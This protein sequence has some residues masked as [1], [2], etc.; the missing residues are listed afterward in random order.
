[1]NILYIGEE[2]R[3][4]VIMLVNELS[5]LGHTITAI[6]K[7]YDEY[8]DSNK[9][10]PLENVTVIEVEDGV[11]FS[12]SL[13][14]SMFGDKTLKTFDIVYGS[15]IIACLPVVTIGK[16][17]NIPCG[18]QVLDIPLD[19]IRTQKF[20]MNNWKMYIK[21]LENVNVMTFITR[22]ARDDWNRI[23]GKYYAD[24]NVITY[25]T[26]VPEEFK[27]SGISIKGNYIISACRLSPIK[28]ISM[29]TKALALIGRPIKQVVIGRD[30]GDKQIITKIALENDIEVKFKNNVTEQEK[31]ELI[32]NSLCVVYPQ[33]SE[34]LGGLNPWE[35]M[36][37][38]KPVICTDYKILKS[39][40]KNHIDYFD[41]TSVQ[42][43][44]DK[45]T[46]I[47]DNDY[48]KEKLEKASNYAYEYATFKTMANKLNKVLEKMKK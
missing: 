8:D 13:L 10:K 14:I 43:L 47:Y 42:A 18:I 34:Y 29:I 40:F 7:K 4:W 33:L 48:N 21:L 36:M 15:H 2:T 44:A 20:R 38:S 41:R 1:M 25:A 32:K 23:T 19:L 3:N 9:I 5:L 28:N 27:N 46:E 12:D 45:I 24:E 37:I 22:K 31:Y 39:L 11:F 6:V 17:Y 35:G 16:K 30:N 26:Y